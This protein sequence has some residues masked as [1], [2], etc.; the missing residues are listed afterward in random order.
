[1]IDNAV[2]QGDASL[3]IA[4]TD[5]RM[6]PV[7]TIAGAFIINIVMAGAVETLAAQGI[8]VD[9]Y[10]SANSDNADSGAGAIAERWRGR[11]KGL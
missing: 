3:E 6:G 10:K 11:I 8:A 4:G 2:A 9:V 5:L 7:S 1:M